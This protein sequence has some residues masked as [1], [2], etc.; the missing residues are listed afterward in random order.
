MH[1]YTDIT[2]SQTPALNQSSSMEMPVGASQQD[3]REA[4]YLLAALEQLVLPNQ[5]GKTTQSTKFGT[6]DSTR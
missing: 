4:A 2:T 5:A 3:E 6:G 1:G